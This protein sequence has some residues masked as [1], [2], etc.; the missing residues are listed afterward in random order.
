MN[1]PVC[2]T[3]QGEDLFLEGL[4]EPY[5][6]ESIRIIR[7]NASYVDAFIAVSHY[8][9]RSMADYLGIDRNSIHVVPSGNQF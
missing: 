1:V 2:C 6:S 5:R 9:A 4:R 3:L 8:G 7:E